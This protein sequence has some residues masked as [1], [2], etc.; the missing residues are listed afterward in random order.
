MSRLRALSL[1]VFSFFFCAMFFLMPLAQGQYRASLHGT[2]TDPQSAI[3][4]GATVT[5]LEP[6]TNQKLTSTTDAAGIYHFN[7]LP[8][9]N[10]QLTVEAAGFT[11][12]VLGNI[13]II[14]E[15]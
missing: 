9:A 1:S 14:P 3:V 7:A 2:V 4:P 12:K 11:K 6:A 13:R 8:P 15:Q 10:Y 5:L